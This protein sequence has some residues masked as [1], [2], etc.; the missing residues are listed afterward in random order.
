M[1]GKE[2]LIGFKERCPEFVSK[3][4]ET[5]LLAFCKGLKKTKVSAYFD[6]FRRGR[7]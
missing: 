2:I 3:K 6:L 7:K 1:V 5:L 4:R